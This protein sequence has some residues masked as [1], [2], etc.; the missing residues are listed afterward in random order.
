METELGAELFFAI[1]LGLVGVVFAMG[2]PQSKNEARVRS[3]TLAFC[4]ILAVVMILWLAVRV[5]AA[6]NHLGPT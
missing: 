3:I 6:V 2:E 1:Y 5:I 4:A